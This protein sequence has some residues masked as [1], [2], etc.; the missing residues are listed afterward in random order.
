M[1]DA[2]LLAEINKKPLKELEL[3]LF[4]ATRRIEDLREGLIKLDEY[5]HDDHFGSVCEICNILIKDNGW[6]IHD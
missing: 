6:K 4:V 2:E 5:L 3:L 1:T